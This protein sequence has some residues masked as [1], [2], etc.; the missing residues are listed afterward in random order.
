MAWVEY[1]RCSG[2]YCEQKGGLKR[3][4]LP[5]PEGAALEGW[6]AEVIGSPRKD[7]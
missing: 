7:E 6:I 1:L 5:N 4:V 2:V 3:K